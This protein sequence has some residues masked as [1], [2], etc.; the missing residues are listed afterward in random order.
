VSVTRELAAIPRRRLQPARERGRGSHL[1][2]DQ[3]LRSGLIDP[4]I[5]T[6][7]GRIVKRTRG[8]RRLDRA[9]NAPT[10]RTRIFALGGEGR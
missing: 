4:A 6:H 10:Q 7:H 9:A 3:G 1:V 2:A 5:A 8:C